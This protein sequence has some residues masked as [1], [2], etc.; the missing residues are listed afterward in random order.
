[1]IITHSHVIDT[2]LHAC[3]SFRPTV[4]AFQDEYRDLPR[5]RLPHY[6]LMGDI[7]IACSKRL[8][9]G[10]ES[11]LEP[12]FALLE[13]WIKDGDKYVRDMAITGLIEDLQNEN[14]HTGTRPEDFVR[15]LHPETAVYWAK[16][17]R[18]WSHGE[19]I[20]RN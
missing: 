12:L 5:D 11:D 6:M 15:L 16:V 8:S 4:E 20:S 7:A 14:L 9:E 17:N 1:M 3:P 13:K 18:F 19:I 2:L 10:H